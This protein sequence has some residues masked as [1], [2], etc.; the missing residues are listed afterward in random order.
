MAVDVFLKI[1]D[2]KGESLDSKHKDEIEI[3]SFS[4]GQAADASESGQRS[5]KVD[6]QDF[7]F[8]MTIN[9]ATAALMTHCATGEHIT[10]GDAKTGDAMLTVRS[11]GQT[12][13]DFLKILFFDVM[14]SSYQNA[15]MQTD[16]RPMDQFSLWFAKIELEYRPQD[17]K[18][19]L[20]PPVHFKWD[21]IKGETY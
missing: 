15:A 12:P 21:R 2:I 19:T 9:K 16:V 11:V 4:F 1:G 3:E 5:G 17:A 20:G 18:G 6:L 7:Q 13:D 8:V 14:V 10:G